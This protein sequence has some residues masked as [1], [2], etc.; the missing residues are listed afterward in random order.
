MDVFEILKKV[1]WMLNSGE[2]PGASSKLAPKFSKED[3]DNFIDGTHILDDYNEYL[4]LKEK[5]KRYDKEY[6]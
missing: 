6:I 3:I 2:N 1:H 4:R 5:I